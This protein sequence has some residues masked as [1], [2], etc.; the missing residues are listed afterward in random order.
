MSLIINSRSTNVV[1]AGKRAVIK[2]WNR[3]KIYLPM[4]FNDL[5]EKLANTKKHVE[6][7]IVIPE[8]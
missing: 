6:V 8:E 2:E 7:Y 4:Y 5:W 3:F 1:Y